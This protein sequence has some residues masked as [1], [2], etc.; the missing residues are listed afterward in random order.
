MNKGFFCA[1]AVVDVEETMFCLCLRN[2]WFQVVVEGAFG[3][4]AIL[5]GRERA[6]EGLPGWSLSG[7]SMVIKISVCGAELLNPE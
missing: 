7:V 4:R 3:R 1:D 5:Q 2:T 6:V